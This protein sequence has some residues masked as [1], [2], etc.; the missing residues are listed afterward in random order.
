MKALGAALVAVAVAACS[1][2]HALSPDGGGMDGGHA[3][4]GGA[5]ADGGAAGAGAGAS[6]R[7]GA[8][9][10]AGVEGGAGTGGGGTSA[11]GAAGQTVIAIQPPGQTINRNVD[12]LFMIDDSYGMAPKQRL[13]IASIAS[14]MDA[15]KALPGG[16]PNL[17]VGVISSSM[18]AGRNPTV[19]HCPPGGD[20]GALHST[21]L[22]TTCANASLVAGQNFIINVNGMANYTGD[23]ADVFACIAPLGEGGCGFEHQLESVLRALGA[24][25]AA[26]PPQN[27]NFLRADAF[28]QIVLLSD[29]DDCSAPPDSD[30]FDSTSQTVADPLGPMSSFRCNEFGHLCG[31]RPPPRTPAGEVDLSGTCVSAEDG[32]LLR[33]TDVVTA[34]KRLKA[35][36]SKVFVASIGGPTTPYKVNVGPSLLKSDPSPWPAI[37]HSC[38]IAAAGGSPVTGDPGIRTKQW[39]DAFGDH[40]IFEEICAISLAAP[41]QRIAGQVGQMM[42]APCLPFTVTPDKCQLVDQVFDPATGAFGNETLRRCTDSADPGP[43]WDVQNNPAACAAKGDPIVFKRPGPAVMIESITATC[44]P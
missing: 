26:A 20:R 27:T 14:Y 33:I 2:G 17:H 13:L 41:L 44:A 1:S 19:D 21:P 23:I 38:G 5:G 7:G 40:G 11:G 43:C 22:G 28:L 25:G 12:V 4:G 6:G 15:L 24:D 35:D 8:S 39:V 10:G 31:G 36:P 18:G 30:L 37:E 29:E 34:L 16:L 9:G 32:R 42:G 3:G